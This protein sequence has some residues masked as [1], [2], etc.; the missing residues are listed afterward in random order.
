MIEHLGLGAN[1]KTGPSGIKDIVFQPRT[2]AYATDPIEIG[3]DLTD[4]FDQ[5]SQKYGVQ[6]GRKSGTVFR[7]KRLPEVDGQLLTVVDYEAHLEASNCKGFIYYFKG[8]PDA[9]GQCMSFCFWETAEDGRSASQGPA[10]TKAKLMA[11]LFYESAVVEHLVIDY[12]PS[13]VVVQDLMPPTIITYPQA[14]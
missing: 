6:Y 2:E 12:S 9:Y 13:G 3:V 8:E 14:A 5:L 1:T 4:M 11:G 10:H 7:S